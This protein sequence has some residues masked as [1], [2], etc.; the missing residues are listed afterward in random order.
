MV[1]IKKSLKKNKKE[2]MG[3]SMTQELLGATDN[4]HLS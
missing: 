4:A 2:N 1:H 3:A